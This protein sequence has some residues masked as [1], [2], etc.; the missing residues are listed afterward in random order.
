M[1]HTLN[2]TDFEGYVIEQN[3][4]SSTGGRD[5]SSKCLCAVFRMGIS[6]SV[7]QNFFRVHNRTKDET[8]RF[9]SLSAAITAYNDL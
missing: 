8:Q 3:L 1:R 5:G 4:A 2:A 6:G 9:M 7:A